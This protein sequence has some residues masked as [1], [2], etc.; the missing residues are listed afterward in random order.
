MMNKLRIGIVCHPSI[1]GSGLVATQLGIGLAKLGHEV[2]FI[3]HKRP[4]KLIQN[5]SN[6]YFHE[7]DEVNYPLFEGPLHTYSLTAKIVE[8]VEQYQLHLIH[9]H[10]SI[11]HSLCAFLASNI[12]QY[13]FP[14]VTTIH[15]TDVTIVGQDNAIKRLNT[16]SMNQSTLLTTVSNFQRQYI[17]QEFEINQPINVVHN[18]I[19]ANDFTP[20]LVDQ[21]LRRTL[22]ND[23]EKILMHVSNFRPLKNTQTVVNAFSQLHCDEKVRLVLVGSG[24]DIEKIKQQCSQLNILDRVRFTGSVNKVERYIANADCLI[25]PS[26]RESFCMVILEAMSCGVPTVSSNVDGIPE[27]VEEGVTG[28]MHPPEDAQSM[29][30]TI[31]KIFADN[32]Y[33]QQLG[34]AGRARA[35]QHFN[36]EIKVNQYVDCYHQTLAIHGQA[37]QLVSCS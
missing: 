37:Q 13:S 6:V 34:K 20:E 1:G 2:H 32:Q 29:A 31:S 27:V 26:Y 30:S 21:N 17:Q 7:V 11:P 23:D 36:T 12:C 3:A 14:I 5:Y 8:V 4:F 18:F 24:P 28:F 19:D 22:A 10:Y 25:Q 33:Q 16:F 9:A 15:G 35:I